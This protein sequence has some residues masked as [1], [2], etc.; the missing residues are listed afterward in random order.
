[1]SKRMML[2]RC[3]NAGLKTTTRLPQ[4]SKLSLIRF[5]H[6]IS[7]EYDN[8]E[9]LLE[10]LEYKM[11]SVQSKILSHCIKE[12]VPHYGFTEKALVSSI[13]DLG[14]DSTMLSIIGSPNSPSIFHSSPAVME[15]LKYNLVTK[16][17]NLITAELREGLVNKQDIPSLETLLIQRLKMDKQLGPKALKSLMGQLSIP[18]QLLM[19]VALPELFRLSDDIIYFS[20][21]KDHTDMAWYTKRL[22][23]S[24]TYVTSKLFM[25]QDKSVDYED[26]IEFA[27]WKLNKVMNLGDYYNNVEEYAWYTVMTSFN[28]IKSQISKY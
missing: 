14:Y 9:A 26:T 13:N 11:D 10:P 24:L 18:S 1:M 12:K 7:T 28:L 6:P 2:N 19:E 15:L 25:T 5:Y 21:E 8:S 4:L 3:L 23:L 17:Y 16:R 27:K 20:K 22:G